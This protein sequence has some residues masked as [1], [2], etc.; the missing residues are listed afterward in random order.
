MRR[1]RFPRVVVAVLAILGATFLT[2]TA[3]AQA[4]SAIIVDNA[5]SN[6]TA[7]SN[8]GLRQS[9]QRYGENYHFATRTPAAV[10]RLVPRHHPSTGSYRVEVWYPADSG[11]N[12]ATRS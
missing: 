5:S 3:P 7:S 11:Y 9:S 10:T 2:P 6:F 1:F 8:W 12:N 4:Q